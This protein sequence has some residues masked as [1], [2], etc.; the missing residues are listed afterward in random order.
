M[1]YLSSAIK[2]LFTAALLSET[3][4]H[5]GHDVTA[6]VAQRNAALKNTK[7]DLTHCRDTVTKRDM[8]SKQQKRR[9]A[10]IETARA[11]RGLS[12]KRRFHTLRT[13]NLT[14]VT[15]TSHFSNLTVSPSTP[16]VEEI[17]FS[18]TS[19]ILAAEGEVGPFW[20]EGE[21]VRSNIT[22]TQPGI[23]VTIDAQFI[24]V[25]TCEPIPELMWDLW[26]CNATG[27]YG[28]VIGSGNGDSDDLGNLND[29]FLRGLQPTD[30]DGVAQFESIFPGHYAG[31]ATHMHVLAHINGTTFENGTYMGGQI[32]Y[33]GQLFFD[34]DLISEV[35]TFSPYVEN[36]I[37]IV[38]NVDDRVV[39]SE[40]E[41]GADPIFNYVLLGDTVDQGLFVW[42]EMGVDLTA[43]YVDGATAAAELTSDG[44]VEVTTT[45]TTGGNSTNGTAPSGAP[46]GTAVMG[47]RSVFSLW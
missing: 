15:D 47:K 14:S 9:Q 7:R 30:E 4:A 42:I 20:V 31:R 8:Q 40:T 28:G 25:N 17:I 19:C 39:A 34:Q 33:I 16:G 27:V 12:Q 43:D 2:V 21:Y 24:N 10:A 41:T 22:E 46:S 38:A 5:P 36:T 18:N 13:R 37:D 32:P 1:V 6:E 44:G 29:T 23:P 35:N 45:T 26:H 3:I 11:K